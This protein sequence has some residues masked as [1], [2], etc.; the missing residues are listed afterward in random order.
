MC[1]LC[2]E[3]AG[4][5]S[6]AV[7]AHARAGDSPAAGE[8]LGAGAEELGSVGSR[9]LPRST[10]FLIARIRRNVIF[11]LAFLSQGSWRRGQGGARLR[12][13]AG[14]CPCLPAERGALARAGALGSQ[15]WVLLSC[16]SVCLSAAAFGAVCREGVML[17]SRGRAVIRGGRISAERWSG[18]CAPCPGSGSGTAFVPYPAPM[19]VQTDSLTHSRAGPASG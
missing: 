13:P 9:D 18:V 14:P 7:P 19:E 4:E 5:G 17:W 1:P 6:P 11:V 3:P 12:A 8:G 16:L 10:L 2:Q 15:G